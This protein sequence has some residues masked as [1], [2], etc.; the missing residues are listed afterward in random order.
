MNDGFTSRTKMTVS[1]TGVYLLR[2]TNI[3][4]LVFNNSFCHTVYL[5][6][7]EWVERSGSLLNIKK[8]YVF[9]TVI[10]FR[11]GLL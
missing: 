11:Y 4:T 8:K 1:E 6:K 5:Q 2:L 10:F 3:D 9:L 7:G